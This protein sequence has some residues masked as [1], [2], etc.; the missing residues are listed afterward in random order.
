MSSFRSQIRSIEL[1]I[2]HLFHNNF[3]HLVAVL[4]SL[5][6][7]LLHWF[8]DAC[9]ALLHVTEGL[10]GLLLTLVADLPGLL[11][12]VLG[13]A[14]LL[15]LLWASLHLHLANLLGLEV[16]VLL[17]DWEGE[18]VGELFAIFVDIGLAY[19]DLDLSRNVIAIL[20]RGPR[21][22]HLLLSI[23]VV[24]SRLLPLAVKIDS[25]G[26]GDV[27]D[28]FFL[29][30]AI[31]RLHVAALVVILGGGVNVVSGVAHPVLPCEAPLDLVSLLK[32]LVMDSLHEVIDQLVHIEAD[33]LNIGLNDPGAV[34]EQLRLASLLVLCPAGLLGV[35]LA[36]VLEDDLL[37]LVAV[38][39]L[40]DA[41]APNIG[42]ANVWIIILN[43]RWCWVLRWRG[44]WRCRRIRWSLTVHFVQ[45]G[46]KEND[47]EDWKHLYL[48]TT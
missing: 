35:G 17:L 42:L 5:V 43:W 28:C 36:L 10:D 21:T 29:H 30:V 44:W 26:A 23:S 34:L 4:L 46:A 47:N 2:A 41:V 40:I 6:L 12:T 16:A 24:L 45:T 32:S 11:L 8:V 3:L 31:G 37:H 27:V 48:D 25:I 14:V 33:A 22:H 9:Q 38:G 20:L 15:G 7:A 13:V 19:L 1:H 18:D 39:V